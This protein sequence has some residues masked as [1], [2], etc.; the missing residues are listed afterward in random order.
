[1]DIK[2]DK[3]GNEQGGVFRSKSRRFVAVTMF[4]GSYANPLPMDKT[5]ETCAYWYDPDENRR[6]NREGI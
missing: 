2:T 6:V 1:M 5:E 3:K 4:K